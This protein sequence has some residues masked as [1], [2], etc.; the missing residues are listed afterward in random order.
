MGHNPN[1]VNITWHGG[2]LLH[3]IRAYGHPRLGALHTALMNASRSVFRHCEVC[4]GTRRLTPLLV[5]GRVARMQDGKPMVMAV[6]YN[7]WS[8]MDCVWK[9]GADGSGI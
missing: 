7:S 6:E 9:S 5:R 4:G 8:C 1:K 2:L 3:M